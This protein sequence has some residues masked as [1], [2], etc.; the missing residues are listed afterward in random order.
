[1]DVAPAGRPAGRAPQVGPSG[2]P[3]VWL[4]LGH[5]GSGW[6]LSCGSAR[7]VADAVA[8]RPTPIAIDGLGIERLRGRAKA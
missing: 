5:G 4:N 8:G 3:G 6:A 1:M 7:L 2:A